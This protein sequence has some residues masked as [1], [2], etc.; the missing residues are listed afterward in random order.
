MA[1]NEKKKGKIYM[2]NGQERENW[3]LK[4]K[5]SRDKINLKEQKEL[6]EVNTFDNYLTK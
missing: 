1:G 2:F 4:A 6:D 3:N 5:P